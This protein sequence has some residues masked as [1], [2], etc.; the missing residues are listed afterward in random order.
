MYKY[1]NIKFVFEN[2]MSYM[3]LDFSGALLINCT[4][5]IM[6]LGYLLQYQ[7]G[8]LQIGTY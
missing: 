1:K 3:G 7:S 2:S 8:I 5:Q 4:V 6:I